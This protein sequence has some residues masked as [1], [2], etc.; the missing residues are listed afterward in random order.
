MASRYRCGPTGL[1]RGSRGEN[2]RRQSDLRPVPSPGRRVEWS[3]PEVGTPA[4]PGGISWHNRPSSPMF[5][6]QD[7]IWELSDVAHIVSYA[8]GGPQQVTYGLAFCKIHRASCDSDIVGVRPDGVA[9]VRR[10]VM[11]R[12]TGRC[13]DTGCRKSTG[14][15]CCCR[16]LRRGDDPILPDFCPPAHA[17]MVTSR[18]PRDWSTDR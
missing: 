3:R 5:S 10:D 6:A 18:P 17:T 7:G 8:E 14:D 4:G 11:K 12:P 16:E 2:Q 15:G 1:T 9:Q 13:C